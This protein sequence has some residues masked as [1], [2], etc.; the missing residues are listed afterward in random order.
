[1]TESTLP[2]AHR[3]NTAATSREHGEDLPDIRNGL[4]PQAM[5]MALNPA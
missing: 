4:R 2:A 1:M 5:R 3:L